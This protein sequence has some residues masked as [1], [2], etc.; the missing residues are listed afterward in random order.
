MIDTSIS[1]YI[2]GRVPRDLPEPNPVQR[3]AIT[4][5]LEANPFAVVSCRGTRAHGQRNVTA[6]SAAIKRDEAGARK[7]CIEAGEDPARW[8]GD[9]RA[10]MWTNAVGR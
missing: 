7:Q 8:F 5:Q 2:P 10:R 1:K 6:I 4:K 3:E 9:G